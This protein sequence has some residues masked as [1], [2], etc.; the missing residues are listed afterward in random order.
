MMPQIKKSKFK[1]DTKKIGVQGPI[2]QR[3]IRKDNVK[4]GH[5]KLHQKL[6]ESDFT[7]RKIK[8]GQTIFDTEALKLKYSNPYFKNA[9]MHKKLLNFIDK[10]KPKL[11]PNPNINMFEESQLPLPDKTNRTQASWIKST[12]SSVPLQ[13]S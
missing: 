8:N 11:S 5:F 1:N 3:D 9:D 7:I 12:S 10:R 6:K 13:T 2:F 4:D